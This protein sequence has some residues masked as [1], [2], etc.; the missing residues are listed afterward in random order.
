MVKFIPGPV[1]N[2]FKKVRRWARSE[3]RKL[4][5]KAAELVREADEA[6]A[7]FDDYLA[8]AIKKKGEETTQRIAVR[9]VKMINGNWEV[10]I[11]TDKSD[12]KDMMEG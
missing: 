10:A 6:I 12:N 3:E 8:E 5:E 4:N 7:S 11:A 9:F 2:A 1:R